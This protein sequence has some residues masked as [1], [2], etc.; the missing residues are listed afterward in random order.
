MIA[1]A[2]DPVV[3]PSQVRADVPA[4]LERVVLRCLAKDP[5]ERFPDAESLDRAMGECA[6]DGKWGQE[7]ASRWW[8]E[9]SRGAAALS[10]AG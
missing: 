3:S 10:S 2:R 1:H 8:H 9:A 6:C 4:D 5:S 7:H